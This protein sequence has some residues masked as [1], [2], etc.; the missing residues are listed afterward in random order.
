MSPVWYPDLPISLEKTHCLPFHFEL[1]PITPFARLCLPV[2]MAARLGQQIEFTLNELVKS[3]PS[4]AMRSRLG[5]LLIDPGYAPMVRRAWSSL[6]RKRI[7]GRVSAYVET[8]KR[9]NSQLR[10]INF[11]IVLFNFLTVQTEYFRFFALFFFGPCTCFR[12]LWRLH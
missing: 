3:A 5:V 2:R 4:L 10:F 6:N 1:F 11:T 12:L 7:F 9:K 8:R